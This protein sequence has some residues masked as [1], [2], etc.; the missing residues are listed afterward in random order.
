MAWKRLA[1]HYPNERDLLRWCRNLKDPN[2]Y[3][4]A[5]PSLSLPRKGIMDKI[6][7][8]EVDVY[9]SSIN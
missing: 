9:K 5:R 8:I 1:M 7:I 3:F 6:I 4:E 2:Y